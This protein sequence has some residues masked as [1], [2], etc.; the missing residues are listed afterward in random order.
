MWNS[1]LTVDG[2]IKE[3]LHTKTPDLTET[4]Y[5]KAGKLGGLWKRTQIEVDKNK[6]EIQSLVEAVYDFDGV[7][8]TKFSEVFQ[9][10]DQVRTTIQGAGGVN[11]ILN[12]VMYAFDMENN[13]ES[14]TT[15]GTG[16]LLIQA[17]PESLTAGAV[18]G[19]SF[20]LQEK[21]VKQTVTVRKDVDFIPEDDKTYYAISAKVKKNTVGTA[22]IKLTNRNETLI[23]DLPD[24]TSYYWDTVKFEEILPLDDYY[25]IE[26][27][28]DDDAD[29]QVT[30]LI[31]APGKTKREW[32]QANGEVMNATST[33]TTE[34]LTM[35]S[36]QFPND[37]TKLDALGLEVHSKDVG[38]GRVFGFNKD[39]TNV[40]KLKADKQISMAP[41][42]T[43]PI[44]YGSYKGW[45]FTIAKEEN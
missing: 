29:L 41:L 5:N 33:F 13:P 26:I 22:W 6:Q 3:H 37:Y 34:G 16:S 8:N 27:Y 28:S 21:T 20:T 44:D 31:F 38:G 43:V 25:D 35:R 42:R 18:A 45:A 19:N 15:S 4:D 23:I 17:S 9:D 11:L 10:V 12:S 2:G 39:E 30:D 1:K 36:P 24:Q 7:I 40:A 32:T 14:W